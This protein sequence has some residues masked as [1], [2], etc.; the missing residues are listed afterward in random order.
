MLALVHL[1]P[2]C[3]PGAGRDRELVVVV[4]QPVRRASSERPP[5]VAEDRQ[6]D[7]AARDQSMSKYDAYRDAGPCVSTSHHHG[8]AA[9]TA[10]D[11]WLGTMS[12]HEPEPGRAHRRHQRAAGPASPPQLRADAR[13]GSTTS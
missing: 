6:Q 7:R 11:M 1:L 12:T 13:V 2:A 9:G 3:R 5:V 8:F 4:A 10:T